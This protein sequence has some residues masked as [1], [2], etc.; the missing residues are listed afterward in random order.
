MSALIYRE[1]QTSDLGAMFRLDELCFEPQFRFTR[2]AMQRFAE[3]RN[4]LVVVADADA[5]LAGFCIVHVESMRG[6]TIGYVVTLDVGEAFR[7]RGAAGRLMQT[8][9]Q[10]ARERNCSAMMLHVFTGNDAAVRFYERRG[11]ARMHEVRNFYG[12][13]LHAFMYRKPLTNQ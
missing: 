9:E 3:A 2:I 5:E 1:Y 10:G 4:A 11:Y 12:L 6:E 13:N 7:R 8:I